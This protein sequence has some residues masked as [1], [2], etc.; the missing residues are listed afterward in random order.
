MEHKF[1]FET[2]FYLDK[3]TG[4]W[5]TTT[6]PKKR[7]HV[8]VW[9]YFNGKVPEKFHVH[10]KDED[11]S[12]NDIS[13][14]ELISAHDHM[15]MHMTEENRERARKLCGKIRPLTKEWH[16]SEVGRKWH[17][18]HGISGWENR[19]DIEIQCIHCEKMFST[20]AYH[21]I[22]CSP[23]CKSAWRRQEGLDDIDVKCTVCGKIFRKN[24]YDKKK[25][26]SCSCSAKLRWSEKR[27]KDK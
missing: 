9:E 19:E 25:S 6:C 10:H 1:F 11:K 14:L 26:C 18:E 20:K 17:K 22:F 23:S 8:V 13:N 16:S 2:K 15:S 7:L 21:S 4:Y 3:K 5:I 27:E 12:N 24:K